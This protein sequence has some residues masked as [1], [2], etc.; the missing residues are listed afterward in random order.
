MLYSDLKTKLDAMSAD[1][2]SRHVTVVVTNSQIGSLIQ[3][4]DDISTA[5][6]ILTGTVNEKVL[7]MMGTDYPLLIAGKGLRR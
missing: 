2:L 4:V 1:E 5:G 6:A 3:A 7:P